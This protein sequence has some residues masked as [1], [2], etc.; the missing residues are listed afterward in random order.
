MPLR[1][2]YLVSCVSQ[3]LET[4]APAR[5]LYIST[6]FRRA[7]AF[8]EATRSPWFILSAKYGLIDP[9]QT[10]ARYELTL[11]NM[12]AAER[13]EWAANV[14]AQMERDLPPAD[15]I[16]MLAGARYREHLMAYLSQRFGVEPEAPL[17]HLRIGEQSKWFGDQLSK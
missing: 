16:V 11:N 17:Q 14:L 10:I 4:P 8:V 13:R 9:N 6:W 12:G 15:R 7:R 3:K 2:T 1:T 5:E